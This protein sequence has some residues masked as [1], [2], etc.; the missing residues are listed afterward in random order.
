MIVSWNWLKEYVDL[1]MSADELAHRLMMAGLNHEGTEA[2][3]QDLAID[4]EVT[5]N[6]PDCLGHIGVAR[7]ISVLW[8]L[9]LRVPK[10][11]PAESTPTADSLVSVAVECPQMC[12]Q[13]SARVIR[14][15]QVGPSPAWMVDRLAT[16]GLPSINN[17]VDITNYVLMECGQP[18]HAFDLAKLEGQRIVVRPGRDKEPFEAINHKSYELDSSICVI[19]DAHGA[20]ALGGVMGGA[21]TEVGPQTKDI[22]LESAEFDPV[23]IR[24]A[25]RKLNLHSDSSYRFERGVDPR[26]VDWASRRAAE[27]ILELAGGKLAQGVVAVTRELDPPPRV[28]LR[29]AQLL[30]VL[31]IEVP[32]QRA[33]QILSDLG[34]KQESLDEEQVVV[35]PPSWRSD[36][37][38]EIDLVEE[39][40]RIHGYDQIPEDV[41][42]PMAASTLSDA[43]RVH[44]RIRF[45]LRAHGLD[46]AMTSSAVAEEASDAFSPWCDVAAVRSST[47]VLRGADRLRRSLIPSLLE[48]RRTNE[49]LSNPTI[50]LFE[51]AKVYLPQADALPEE[52]WMLG[53]S[54]G[55][56]L[57]AAKGLVEALLET[58]HVRA[59]LTVED[60]EDPM[61]ESGKAVRLRLAGQ[62][63]GFLGELSPR[64]RKRFQLRQPSTVAELR[65][66]ALIEMADLQP[67]HH[68]LPSHPSMQRDLNLVVEE[69]IRW[70]DLEKTVRSAVGAALE[71]LE[72]RETYRSEQL[73][74]GTKSLL[75]SITLRDPDRTMT[76]ADADQLRD[77]IVE[78]CR[79]A[80]AAQ[81]R[82]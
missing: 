2:V 24:S 29:F 50:E 53:L 17:V 65:L 71:Q 73:D 10:A 6:R 68:K 60:W 76:N 23:S 41:H 61:L 1:D 28:T 57:L 25:A 26:G 16:L 63:W 46:E 7:E 39:V 34:M 77:Q 20:V 75:F 49:A 31:G 58:L 15:I 35:S 81:L 80:H 37:T 18:L 48:V 12:Q 13:Y 5:S 74:A 51:T 66:E 40:A 32:P 72:Y 3:G 70:A 11:A 22:L 27:L 52:A 9:P 56:D 42:V 79:R 33:C 67:R 59:E 62:Q 19:A 8:D 82:E 55:G 14:G 43:D 21:A 54:T 4:L 69:A 36:L 30:R 44:Q 45:V 38:R 64:G 47:P 78:S